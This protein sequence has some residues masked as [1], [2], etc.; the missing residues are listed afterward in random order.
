MMTA[1]GSPTS[2]SA[3][4][5]ATGRR[6]DEWFS[7]LE[8]HE[9]AMLDH[10]AIVQMIGV[11]AGVQNE[12]WSEAVT[13]GF[14]QH[15]GR[16]GLAPTAAGRFHVSAERPFRSSPARAW[17]LLAS[18]EGATAWLGDTPSEWWHGDLGGPDRDDVLETAGGE[19][20]E[21]RSFVAGSHIRLRTLG[22][23]LPDTTIQ[24]TIIPDRG[25]AIV[26]LDQQRISDPQMREQMREHW[27]RALDRIELLLDDA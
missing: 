5:D 15:I 8:D 18:S 12:W 16:P 24:L 21:V 13:A 3:V 25:R 7:W 19:Q 4:L 14:E 10:A 20:Y 26:G 1:D 22:P 9:A 6:W 23:R 11:D 27:E 17:H 2:D